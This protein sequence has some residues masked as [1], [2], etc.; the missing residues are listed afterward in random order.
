MP[1]STTNLLSV[2]AMVVSA[3]AA[4]F[5]AWTAIWGKRAESDNLYS[6]IS[7]RLQK[8]LQDMLETKNREL[9]LKNKELGLKNK[10]LELK[11]KELDLLRIYIKYL[12]E[13]IES[14]PGATFIPI[15]IDDFNIDRIG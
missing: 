14:D 12:L 13:G 5:V 4:L 10:E 9:E 11:D 3:V 8:Q 2:L 6:T 15:D 1:E 7:A